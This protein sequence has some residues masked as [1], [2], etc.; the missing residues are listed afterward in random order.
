VVDAGVTRAFAERLDDDDPLAPLRERFFIG[1]PD[2]LYLDGNSLGRMPLAAL[3]AVETA[4]RAGWGY[5][6]VR[7]WQEWIDVGQQIGDRL[8]QALLG[9]APGETA[10]S[11]STSVNL[12]KLAA[13]ALDA[14]AGRRVVL[15]SAD[16]FPTDRYVLEGLAAARGLDLRMLRPTTDGVGVDAVRAALGPEVAL[17]SLSH[18]SYLSGAIEDAAAITAAAHDAGALVLWDLCHSVGALPVELRAWA[19]D[20]AV[21][22]TYKYVN[23]GPGAPAFVYVRRELQEELRQPIW[24]WFGQRDQFEM[25]PAYDPEPSITRYLVGTPPVL[26]LLPIETGVELLAEAGLDRLREK[27]MRLTELIVRLW[28]SW[29]KPLGFGLASPRD[30]ARRGSHVALSHPEAYGVCQALV[31]ARVVPDFRRPDLIRLGA[32][33]INT[34]FVDVWDAMHRLR[35]LMLANEHRRFDLTPGRVT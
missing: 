11:D 12:Y 4:M 8:G 16:N 7:A 31:A 13:A 23:A 33:P 18:V 28:E 6:L 14:R 20:L 30:A 32:A 19:V 1:D 24:G 25:G 10:V 21:G 17:V 35:R 26:S 29:L 27:S 9:A 22:C 5:R 15:T 3:A 34:R 2:Q